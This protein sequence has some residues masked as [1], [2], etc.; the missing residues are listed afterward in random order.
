MAGI[1]VECECCQRTYDGGPSV[2]FT[3][4]D[5]SQLRKMAWYAGWAGTMD[6]VSSDELCPK[7]S[8]EKGINSPYRDILNQ[9]VQLE[10]PDRRVDNLIHNVLNGNVSINENISD[11]PKYTCQEKPC[12]LKR[13]SD[14][15]DE[16]NIARYTA[17]FDAASSLIDIYIPS[18]LEIA[19]C[20]NTCDEASR[21]TDSNEIAIPQ[22]NRPLFI[23]SGLRKLAIVTLISVFTNIVE[24]IDSLQ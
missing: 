14:I 12:A 20:V 19:I 11:P 16:L 5:V 24:R 15:G 1:F 13:N 3:R 17:S 22:E 6:S 4:S 10:K 21:D 2:S 8:K 18:D 9:L 7:C 23:E